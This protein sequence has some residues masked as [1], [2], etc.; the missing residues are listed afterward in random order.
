MLCLIFDTY[1][2]PEIR[3]SLC[4]HAVNRCPW[5]YW[6]VYRQHSNFSIYRSPKTSSMTRNVFGSGRHFQIDGSG[7]NN[8]LST[9]FFEYRRRWV[10][11]LLLL[12]KSVVGKFEDP[13]KRNIWTEALLQFSVPYIPW[14]KQSA[15]MSC[16]KCRC[17]CI[18]NSLNS[19]DDC[20]P[21]MKWRKS[22]VRK[23]F[24]STGRLTKTVV[25]ASQKLNMA[26]PQFF[27]PR[28]KNLISI[29]DVVESRRLDTL[30]TRKFIPLR[31]IQTSEQH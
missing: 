20:L 4:H 27:V 24:V 9:P 21:I 15:E 17:K 5:I 2:Y 6:G 10:E 13:M 1:K 26:P 16:E 12:A 28:M 19:K 18:S 8:L 29:E 23:T 25:T 30:R 14:K 3:K 7:E 22:P 11:N 31:C